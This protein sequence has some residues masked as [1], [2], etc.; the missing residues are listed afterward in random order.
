MTS[1]TTEAELID[2]ALASLNLSRSRAFDDVAVA[3]AQRCATGEGA[4]A[5]VTALVT[6]VRAATAGAWHSGERKV[7][8]LSLI[9][10]AVLSRESRHSNRP[11]TCCA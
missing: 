3:L 6:A 8:C 5:V 9:E 7:V 10:T 11:S 2:L 4:R 1:S